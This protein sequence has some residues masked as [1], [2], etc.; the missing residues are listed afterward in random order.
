MKNKIIMVCAIAMVSLLFLGCAQAP[1][2][3]EAQVSVSCDEFS[4]NRHITK[5]VQIPAGGSVEV[6]LCSNPSTGFQWVQP[7][8][9]DM[10]LLTITDHK[11]I[12]PAE[13]AAPGTPGQEVWSFK[14]VKKG[15]ATV[16]INYSQPWEGG[17]KG[18][19]IFRMT[20]TIT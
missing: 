14:G 12:A 18:E 4:A 1:I 5:E 19:W 6:T 13:G 3:E 11:V 17:Q 20:V 16:I 8:I 10:N 2:Q 9:S 15:V 7:G